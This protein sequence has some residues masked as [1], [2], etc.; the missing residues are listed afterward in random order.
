MNV[1]V[2]ARP[3]WEYLVNPKEYIQRLRMGWIGKDIPR[4]DARWMAEWLARLSPKQIRDAFRAAGY[5]PEEVEGFSKVVEHRI[6]ALME[7]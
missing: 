6:A 3:A 1:N 2:P 5:S 7:L 4:A